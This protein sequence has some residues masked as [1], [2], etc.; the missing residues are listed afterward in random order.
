MHNVHWSTDVVTPPVLEP[1]TLARAKNYLRIDVADDD[2]LVTDLITAAR[3]SVEAF[4][5]RRII[6]ATLNLLMDGFPGR[7]WFT[8]AG[9][10]DVPFPRLQSVVTIN[11]FDTAGVSTLLPSADYLV[12]TSSEPGRVTPSPDALIWPATE[13]RVNAVTVQ[14]VAG[15]GTAV[16]DVPRGVR[17]AILLMVADMYEHRETQSE[18]RLFDNKTVKALLW[19]HKIALVA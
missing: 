2:A 18:I 12:D 14:F 19:T 4:L 15:Y 13:V 8:G 5:G 11:Y 17:T 16:D 7:R 6:T 10:I 1:V 9:T 3:E